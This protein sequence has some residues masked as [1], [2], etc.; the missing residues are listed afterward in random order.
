[1]TWSAPAPPDRQG[2]LR[3]LHHRQKYG[4]QVVGR[5]RVDAATRLWHDK[6]ARKW[7]SSRHWPLRTGEHLEGA[8]QVRLAEVL[9]ANPV[10]DDRLR[11]EGAA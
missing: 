7:S 11:D 1:M 3:L 4:A 10:A 2:G 9:E 5:V 6:P 8:E